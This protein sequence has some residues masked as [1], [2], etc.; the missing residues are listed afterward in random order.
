MNM[1]RT[2]HTATLLPDGRVLIVGR[3]AEGG[4]F[5]PAAE[6]YD[7]STGTFTIANNWLTPRVFGHTATLLNSGKVL[8]AGGMSAL[9]CCTAIADAELYDPATGW[10]SSA[11]AYAGIPSTSVGDLMFHTATLL[12]DGKVL[13]TYRS[14]AQ[15]YDPATDAFTSTGNPIYSAPYLPAAALLGSGKVLLAGGTDINTEYNDAELYDPANG[16]FSSTNPSNTWGASRAILLPN[17][18]VLLTGGHDT[19]YNP[20]AEVYEPSRGIFIPVCDTASGYTANLLN[21]GRVLITGGV[22]YDDTN[23]IIRGGAVIYTPV[24]LDRAQLCTPFEPGPALTLLPLLSPGQA[25]GTLEFFFTGV[26]PGSVIPPRV[27]IGGR[28]AEVFSFGETPGQP[29]LGQVRVMAPGS[30]TPGAPLPVRLF[31]MGRISNE[32]MVVVEDP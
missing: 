6:I 17:G 14:F 19:G 30:A 1:K 20:G 32:T 31:Y 12:A 7:P 4:I 9:N 15:L 29:G 18:T 8:I 22:Y 11:G 27:S 3:P 26:A 5:G 21:D 16:L 2:A 10:F 23:P 28:F 24:Y 25:A 13:I